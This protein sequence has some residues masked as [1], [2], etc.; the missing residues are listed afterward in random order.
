[1]RERETGGNGK[2]GAVAVLG[3]GIAGMQASLDLAEAGFRVYLVEREA[4]IGGRMA[5]LDKTFP[6][7]DCAMCTISPRLTACDKHPNIDIITRAEAVSVDGEAGRFSLRVRKHPTFVDPVKCNACGDCEAVCPV[8]LPDEFNQGLGP[9]KVIHKLYPQTVPNKYTID[10]GAPP[11]CRLTCPAGVN[12]QGYVA[13]VS[14]KKYREAVALIRQRH[15]LPSV[16]GR[17]CHHPCESQCNRRQIDEGLA[18]NALK[19]FAADAE[20]RRR[21]EEG[22]GPDLPPVAAPRGKKVAVV[23]SGPAGLTAASDLACHGYAVTV[24]EAAPVPGGMLRLGI[25]EYRLP[26]QVL[27]EEIDDLLAQGIELRLNTPIGP[28]LTL[29]DLKAQGYAAVFL[30]VGAHKS[31]RLQIEGTQLE[32]VLHGV[33]FLRA[34]S[35]GEKVEVGRRVVVIGGGNVAVDVAQTA[36]RLGAQEVH[37]ACLESR[38]QMPAHE[39]EIEDAL[40]ERIV[41]HCS[42]GPKRIVGNGRASGLETLVCS[43]VF[44]ADGR[45]N[46]RLDPGTEGLIEGDTVIVA[47]GQQTDLDWLGEGSPVRITRRGTFEVDPLTLQTSAEGIFAGGDAATGPASAVQ[48]VAQ[49]H[50]AAESIRRYLEGEDL[51]QGR[52]KPQQAPAGVPP[53]HFERVPRQQMARLGAALRVRGFAEIELGLTEEQAVAEASRCLNCGLCSECLQ[54]VA[55]CQPKAIDHAMQEVV[56]DLQVGAVIMAPGFE[57]YD[58]RLKGEYGYGRHPNVVTSL[59]FERMLSASGPYL[60]EVRRP[61]DGRHPRRIAWIQCVGSRDASCGNGY[62]S[63][64]C[65]MYA[66]KEA[67]MAREHDAQVEPTIFYNDVR[68]FGKGFERYYESARTERGVRYVKSLIS[69]VKERPQTRNLLLKYALDDGRVEEEEFDLVVLSVGLTPSA[70]AREMAERLDVQLGPYGFVRTGE[71]TPNQTSQPGILVCGAFEQPMDIPEAVTSASSAAA[72]AAEML[73]EA[74]GTL[75]EEPVYPPERDVQGEEPRVG[76]FVCHCGSNIARTV[77]VQEVVAYAAT[78]PHVAHAEHNL[79]TCSTD[80]QRH[81]VEMLAEYRLNRVVVASCTPRTHEPL[82]RDTLRQAGLNPYLFEM[83]NIRDQCSWVHAELPREA[84][85]KA[86]GLVRMAAARAATLEPLRDMSFEVTRSGLVIGGGLSGMSAALSLAGQ[87]YQV[88]LVEKGP[89]LGGRLRHLRYTLGDADPASYLRDLLARIEGEPRISVYT[90]ADII[91][92]SGHVG[93]FRTRILTGARE[94]ELEHGVV[95]VATGGVE[96]RPEEYLYGQD[97]RVLTQTELERRLADGGPAFDAP[98]QVVMIQCVGSR[99]DEHP[100]CSRVCCGHAIKN[101]LRLKKHSPQT[102]VYVFYRDIRAYGTMEED[103]RRARQAGVLFIRYEPEARPQVSSEGGVLQVRGHD[104]VLGAQVCLRPDFLVL[105]AGIRPHPDALSLGTQLKVPRTTDGT[106]LEA[107]LKLRP[108]DFSNEGMFLCGL[109]HS[110]KFARESI[111]QARGAAARAATVLAKP[112]LSVPATVAHVDEER[113]AACLTCVRACPFDVPVIRDGAAYIEAAMCQGC[114][115]C[116]AACPAKAI[117]VG[118]YRDA[119]IIP[120][121]ET[122]GALPAVEA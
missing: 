60:G 28:G 18:V 76:V 84:T 40:E 91:A 112:E 121:V 89:E 6:T 15:P 108:V 5:Q 45:F 70:R 11:P 95:I 20:R 69:T 34:V 44:D 80:A 8:R 106:F 66:T 57:C 53:R 86:K 62:C 54:C 51:R 104:P 2:V 38:A 37:L 116:A 7:N 110:P 31:R 111:V 42:R 71:F 41:L 1:M 35:L 120:M 3:G 87:G 12:V 16:C 33:E 100:Y 94:V 107:H 30:A 48:A 64:V 97:A 59:E 118:H 109:A 78:L 119:Q 49:G 82:F 22:A 55:V 27:Q 21:R 24:F 96:H 4:G 105:S 46:P 50:E 47:I 52:E 29:E 19:R 83:T 58:A 122:F 117:E 14:Q 13:L 98:R 113:C 103:Y 9:R 115:T 25:P 67:V 36:L 93:H 88:H 63:S 92:F 81:I 101:A 72:L 65:C 26:R 85:Q 99:D 102:Q 114:G 56:V 77:A 43:S 10:K 75:V 90:D 61:S 32:G 68:A 39:W 79:Y 17:V 74:R 23:G 73:A